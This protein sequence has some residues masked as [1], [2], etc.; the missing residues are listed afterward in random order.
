VWLSLERRTWRKSSSGGDGNL[1]KVVVPKYFTTSS[2]E[3]GEKKFSLSK[4]VDFDDKFFAERLRAA[5]RELAGSWFRRTFSAR[6]LRSIQ[7]Q[8]TSTWSGAATQQPGI[9]VSGFLAVGEGMEHTSDPRSPFAE[10]SLMKLYRKPVTGKARYTWVHWARRVSASNSLLTYQPLEKSTA[11]SSPKSVTTIQFLHTPSKLR[12]LIALLLMLLLS[13]AAALLWIS[14]GAAGTGYRNDI[15]RQRSDR[16][17]GG[18]AVGVLVLLPESVGFGAW[19][20][21]N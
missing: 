21:F 13:I 11:S 19:V 8:Q 1:V 17:G 18:M 12:M 2:P 10:E 6:K 16:V 3:R 9:S 4:E 20:A 5:H 15:S 14:L 7:L